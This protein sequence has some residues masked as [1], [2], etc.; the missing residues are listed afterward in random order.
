MLCRVC[1]VGFGPSLL[2]LLRLPVLLARK[3]VVRRFSMRKVFSPNL[4]HSHCAPTDRDGAP[5][6]RLRL[7]LPPAQTLSFE[8]DVAP[9]KFQ[10]GTGA[11]SCLQLKQ[12]D[13][14]K[15]SQL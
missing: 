1:D 9:R 13:R 8:I 14:V 4:E 2:A 12:H 5:G 6:P 15:Q 11:R 3:D 7:I 10:D